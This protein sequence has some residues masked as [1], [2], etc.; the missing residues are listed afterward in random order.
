MWHSSAHE[1]Y[2]H[3]NIFFSEKFFKER[4]RAKRPKNSFAGKCDEMK[5]VAEHATLELSQQLDT[6]QHF[7]LSY[8]ETE[9]KQVNIPNISPATETKHVASGHSQIFFNH[10]RHWKAETICTY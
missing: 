7:T 1:L 2:L 9:E 8:V 6:D 4:I 3:E 5:S 10:C